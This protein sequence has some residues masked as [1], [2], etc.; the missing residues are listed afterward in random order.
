MLSNI[1]KWLD[2]DFVIKQNSHSITLQD[3]A[4]LDLEYAMSALNANSNLLYKIL[5]KFLEE[6]GDDFISLPELLYQN[7]EGA[8]ALIHALK[9]VSSN[10]GAKELASIATHIDALLKKSIPIK[11]QNIELLKDAI[12][13]VEDK[14]KLYLKENP[15]LQEEPTLNKKLIENEFQ[16]LY[17]THLEDIKNGTMVQLQNQQL[18]FNLLK[19]KVNRYELDLWMSAMDNFDY[20]KAYNIM[21]EWQ[22]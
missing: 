20:D 22:L 6:L 9:G 21:K 18:L 2:I 7:D 15:P 12:K 13:R 16:N 19:P 3:T 17:L 11:A 8:K 10:I 5:S 14:I 4:V 1:A